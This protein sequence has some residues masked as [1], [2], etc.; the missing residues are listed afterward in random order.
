[1]KAKDPTAF[2]SY[3]WDSSAHSAWVRRL[4][5]GL[6]RGGVYTRLD[7]WDV[8]PGADVLQFME[9]AIRQSSFV[10]VV[11]TPR[12]RARAERRIGGVG[13]ETALITADVYTK[14]GMPE[15]YIPLLVV[16]APGRS[17]PS[18]LQTRLRVDFRDATRYDDNLDD[19]LRA[20]HR[21]PAHSRPPLGTSPFSVASVG[22]RLLAR[23]E[24]VPTL[25]HLLSEAEMP[26]SVLMMDVVGFKQ[27][28]D[29]YGHLAG[30]QVISTLAALI[31]DTL[32]STAT[33]VRW[34]GDEFVALLPAHDGQSA[35]ALA[36]YLRA[37]VDG[38]QGLKGARVQ[39][40]VS[41]TDDWKKEQ[42]VAEADRALYLARGNQAAVVRSEPD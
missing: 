41:S 11:C 32:P 17:I 3:S 31:S 28:N 19:L 2:I 40:G 35:I 39:V 34:G 6:H 26:I 7:Q 23:Q 16:G 37:R 13:Y 12:Y 4:A 8:L 10:L 29:T 5:H 20:L 38:H 25:D 1:M 9:S 33:V 21:T 22:G 18:F 24:F 30:D 42:L 15:K 14:V 36:E 27:I